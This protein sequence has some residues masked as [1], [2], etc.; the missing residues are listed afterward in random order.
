MSNTT[1]FVLKQFILK[2]IND[3][4][5]NPIIILTHECDILLYKEFVTIQPEIPQRE[6]TL[7]T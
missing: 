4:D 1:V 5:N 3:I 7:K 2:M 6:K